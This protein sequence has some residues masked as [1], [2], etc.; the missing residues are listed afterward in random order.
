MNEYCGWANYETWNVSLWIGNDFSLYSI[1]KD[2]EDYD[3]FVSV[4]EGIGSE[5]TPDNV[6][7]C[8]VNLCKDQLDDFIK[9]LQV[10]S[11]FWIFIVF[12]VFYYLD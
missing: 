9:G 7:W 4:I 12:V 6:S 1:A 3:S 8:D 11:I 10:G 2:C 5:D